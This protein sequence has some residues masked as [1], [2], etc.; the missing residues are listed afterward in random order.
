MNGRDEFF[1]TNVIKMVGIKLSGG[2][3]VVERY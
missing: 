2:C 3:D 1:F